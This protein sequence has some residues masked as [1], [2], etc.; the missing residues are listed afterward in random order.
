MKKKVNP[1][2]NV[3]L[4]TAWV[5]FSVLI[6]SAWFILT[7]FQVFNLDRSLTL[8][9]HPAYVQT[10]DEDN[11]NAKKISY[12][13][14]SKENNLGIVGV[15]LEPTSNLQGN[16]TFRIKSL[17]SD[18]WYYEKKYPTK[19]ISGSSIFPFGFSVIP[20][21]A[22]KNY[23]VELEVDR[24]TFYQTYREQKKPEVFI[25][26]KF[27]RQ[28]LS[29]NSALLELIFK[30]IVY[31]T[32]YLNIVPVILSIFILTILLISGK[33]MLHTISSRIK[34]I[35]LNCL[36]FSRKIILVLGIGLFLRLLLATGSYNF[37]VLQWLNIGQITR[38]HIDIYSYSNYYNY[39]PVW[40]FVLGLLDRF[41]LLFG[42][43]AQSFIIRA[44]LSLVDVITF[45]LL[46]KIAIQRNLPPLKTAAL[47]FLSPIAII[48]SGHH[49]QFENM[50]ILFLLLALYFT[51]KKHTAK[52]VKNKFV[53]IFLTLGL[54][55]KHIVIFPVLYFFLLFYK[56][57][58]LAI[59]LFCTSCAIF[60]LTLAPFFPFSGAQIVKRVFLYGGVEGLYGM[61]YFLGNIFSGSSFSGPGLYLFY[62]VIFVLTYLIFVLL[63]RPK[64]IAR[65]I[66][67]SILFFLTF[68][69]GIG[70]QYF[71]LPVAFGVFFPTKWFYLYTVAVTLFFLGSVD[72][73]NIYTFKVFEWNIV[74]LF[75]IL[76]FLSELMVVV[77]P[78]HKLYKKLFYR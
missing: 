38:S 35:K 27:T 44:F 10:L 70:A 39:S 8:L 2:F 40:F 47:F 20:N 11:V 28:D 54:I 66:L 43:T 14:P 56:N 50:A 71:V 15:K 68:T 22:D 77:T 37:D 74:W 48:I 76:W 53:F 45:L 23:I 60:L 19:L 42:F 12:T 49:G 17:D 31:T 16:T 63:V 58:F 7:F 78:L 51:E 67:L 52:K 29:S 6:L 64:D 55:M 34:K 21:S 30:K 18:E 57:R 69:S 59:F 36:S 75:T 26:Y 72:E 1:N 62:K 5:I 33:K 32:A 24:G 9:S 61:T 25:K 4:F 46:Y 65:G 73:L 3:R 13:F 41:S